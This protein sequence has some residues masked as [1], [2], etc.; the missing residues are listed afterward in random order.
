MSRQGLRLR[1]VA[2][3]VARELRDKLLILLELRD[4]RQIA[5]ACVRARGIAKCTKSPMNFQDSPETQATSTTYRA[6]SA[7]L[8]RNHTTSR[9][10]RKD[11]GVL[12]G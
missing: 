2:Q 10:T 8:S 7:Q 3:L 9:A 6:T 1:N 11:G 12:W 4:F 5:H